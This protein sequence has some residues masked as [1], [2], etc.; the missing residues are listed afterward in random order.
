MSFESNAW[1]FGFK[2]FL[3]IYVNLVFVPSLPSVNKKAAKNVFC[4]LSANERLKEM[5]S[6][7]SVVS[8]LENS[9]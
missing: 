1:K 7:K 9:S 8:I 6:R 4:I 5:S 2:S 3:K